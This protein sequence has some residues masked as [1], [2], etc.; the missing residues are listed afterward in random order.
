MAM[1]LTLFC[2]PSSMCYVSLCRLGLIFGGC[3]EVG[4]TPF[5]FTKAAPHQKKKGRASEKERQTKKQKGLTSFDESS[6]RH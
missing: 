6:P 5:F 1:L 4:A 2:M 3:G